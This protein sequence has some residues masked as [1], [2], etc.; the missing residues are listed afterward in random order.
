[1]SVNRNKR[2]YIVISYSNLPWTVNY[3]QPVM[4][5]SVLIRV[6]FFVDDSISHDINV[7]AVDTSDEIIVYLISL[8]K[9]VPKSH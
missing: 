1:M 3:A 6:S 9:L 7:D 2:N 8:S 5:K 4:E